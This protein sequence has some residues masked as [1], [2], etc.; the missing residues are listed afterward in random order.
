MPLGKRICARAKARNPDDGLGPYRGVLSPPARTAG[1]IALPE[2]ACK[3]HNVL[4]PLTHIN[5]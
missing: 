4:T 1:E 5:E 2:L 3:R